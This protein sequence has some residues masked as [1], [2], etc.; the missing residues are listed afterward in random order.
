MN[1]DNEY[2]KILE[3]W[4]TRNISPQVGK[5]DLETCISHDSYLS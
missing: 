4:K 5:N 1:G 3:A 2:T